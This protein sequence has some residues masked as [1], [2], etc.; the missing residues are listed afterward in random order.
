M[1][2]EWMVLPGTSS[3]V[4]LVMVLLHFFSN[5]LSGEE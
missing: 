2:K 4:E 3:I 1:K 5:H